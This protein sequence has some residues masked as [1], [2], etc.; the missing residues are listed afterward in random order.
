MKIHGWIGKILW[1]NLTDGKLTESD[2]TKYA[3]NFIG[4]RGIAARV[5]WDEIPPEADAFDPENRLIIMTGPL[6]GTSAPT[7]GGRVTFAGIAPQ[8]YPKPHYTRSNMGGYWG[9]ELKYAGYDGLIIEGKSCSPV[10]LWIKDGEAEIKD[11]QEIWGLDTFAT[12]KRLMKQYGKTAQSICIGPAGENLVRIATVQSGIE[13][14]AGQGGFGA[15][16]GSKN[17][18][19]VAVRGSGGVPIARPEEFKELCKYASS[20]AH[21]PKEPPR[22][23]ALTHKA[24]GMS[25]STLECGAGHARIFKKVKGKVHPILYTGA[26]QCA[27]P[28]YLR[29]RPWEA[30]FEAAQLANRYGINHWE[31]VLGLTGTGRWLDLCYKEGI[32]TEKDLAMNVDLDSGKFWCEILRKIAYKDGIGKIF[33]EGVP[34]AA[35]ILGK[36]KEHLPHV[37]HGYETH[38]DGHLFGGPRYPYWIVA[39]LQWAMDSRDPLIHCY[40]EEIT[41]WTSRPGSPVSIEQLKAI[42]K[43]LYGSELAV[44]PESNY[45]YKAQPTIWHQNRLAVDDSVPVCEEIFPTIYSRTS[46]DGFGDTSLESK[47][48]SAATGV[49]MTEEELDKVGDRIYNLER[50]IMVREGRTRRVDETVI[51]YFEKPDR[52]GIRLDVTKFRAL[53]DE[54]Y[55]IRGWDPAT[56]WPKRE[57]LV[58]LGLKD[59]ADELARMKHW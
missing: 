56:G 13:N 36:G 44:D 59:V 51:P 48:F 21:P 16:M 29:F 28:A 11:G 57:K 45:E 53:M 5:A 18:K 55:N 42:G 30:G 26:V 6:N 14:A 37:A 47:L 32:I 22:D 54:F 9:A 34:R 19:A 25:C 41:Y 49:D 23:H 20:V 33:A 7:S 12:Q 24:C 35:D 17:L 43:R 27:S 15:V 39:A 4:G 31:I 50:A 1:V 8:A 38:W 46:S 40:A 58:E 2:T 52:A 10:Y 3:R